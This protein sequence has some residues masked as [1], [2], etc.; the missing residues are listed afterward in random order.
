MQSEMDVLLDRI[1]K[2][3]DMM[4]KTRVRRRKRKSEKNREYER[5]VYGLL[6]IFPILE[7]LTKIKS[8]QFASN[9]FIISKLCDL[10]L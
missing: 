10:E 1:N 6:A 3:S 5:E 2:M 8:Y 7:E 9:A 4:D